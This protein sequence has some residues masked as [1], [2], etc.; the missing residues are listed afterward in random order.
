MVLV[1]CLKLG[2]LS[3]M[4]YWFIFEM[5]KVFSGVLKLLFFVLLYIIVLGIGVLLKVFR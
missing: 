1:I 4:V 3:G 2:L 5:E